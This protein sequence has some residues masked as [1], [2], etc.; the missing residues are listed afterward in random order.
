MNRWI[1][2]RLRDRRA[3][4]VGVRR[5]HFAL[6]CAAIYNNAVAELSQ[7]ERLRRAA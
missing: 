3:P 5:Q 7:A 1:K 6:V 4:A 2:E